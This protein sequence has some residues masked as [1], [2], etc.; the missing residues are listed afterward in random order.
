M[1]GIVPMQFDPEMIAYVLDRFREGRA[2]ELA[3]L[4]RNERR[5]LVLVPSPLYTDRLPVGLMIS[6]EGSGCYMWD[7]KNPCDIFDLI[8]SG[9]SIGIA[10]AVGELVRALFPFRHRR[11]LKRSQEHNQR[12]QALLHNTTP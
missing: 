7:G 2:A 8:S 9:F 12:A 10:N 6:C 5:W 4:K 11:K 3:V 1:K